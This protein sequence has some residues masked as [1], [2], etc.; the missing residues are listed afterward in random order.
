MGRPEIDI[1]FKQKAV[2]AIKRSALGIVGLIVKETEKEWKR[3]EYKI[4][5]DIEDKDYSADNL[6]FVK[7]CFE[8]TPSKVVVFNLT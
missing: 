8:F 2:T 7:D 6:R 1:I 3:K 5:T 4:I